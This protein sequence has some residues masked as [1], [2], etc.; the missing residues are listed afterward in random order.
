[1]SSD[2]L[3]FVMQGA[4]VRGPYTI[5]FIEGLILAGLVEPDAQVYLEGGT[6]WVNI[7][8]V[9]TTRSRQPEPDQGPLSNSPPPLPS[10]RIRSK[11]GYTREELEAE[12]ERRKKVKAIEENLAQQIS[13]IQK[14]QADNHAAIN[15]LSGTPFGIKMLEALN[16]FNGTRVPGSPLASASKTLRLASDISPISDPNAVIQPHT[17]SYIPVAHAVEQLDE[18]DKPQAIAL[19]KVISDRELNASENLILKTYTKTGISLIHKEIGGRFIL[20]VEGREYLKQLVPSSEQIGMLAA[21]GRPILPNAAKR[22][23]G[24]F[25][26]LKSN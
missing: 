19:L 7:R 17:A 15:A 1:M 3:Y 25:G 8:T 9:Q 4:E 21:G 16:T 11:G 5:D 22:P 13:E 6:E 23:G 24:L 20:S 10:S 14:D 26:F 18:K 12:I 2:P